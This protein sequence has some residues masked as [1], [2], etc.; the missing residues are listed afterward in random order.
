LILPSQKQD[1]S[2][3]GFSL[4][5]VIIAGGLSAFV[6]GLSAMPI[7]Q[8]KTLEQRVEFQSQLTTAHQ[9]A[10]Q[11]ARN[12]TF[13]KD[14]KRLNIIPGNKSDQ[15]FG[16]RGTGCSAL[17]QKEWLVIDQFAFQSGNYTATSDVSIKVDCSFEKCTQVQVLVSTQSVVSGNNLPIKP[18]KAEFKIPAAALASR[19]E[20]DFSHCTDIATGVTKVITGINYQTLKAECVAAGSNSCAAIAGAGPILTFGPGTDPSDPANCQPP[21]NAKC[22]TGMASI[23]LING[24]TQCAPPP[25]CVDPMSKNCLVTPPVCKP[26]W[27]PSDPNAICLDQV[28]SQSDLNNCGLPAKT[29][30]GINPLVCISNSCTFSGPIKWPDRIKGPCSNSAANLSAGPNSTSTL[31]NDNLG[32]HGNFTATCQDLTPADPAFDWAVAYASSTCVPVQCQSVAANLKW[33]NKLLYDGSADVWACEGTLAPSGTLSHDQAASATNSAPTATSGSVQ[34][35]CV[36]PG[37]LGSPRKADLKVTSIHCVP[38]AAPEKNPLACS[39]TFQET[40]RVSGGCD[41]PAWNN[42]K[43]WL[44]AQLTTMGVANPET[45]YNAEINTAMADWY[46]SN[47]VKIRNTGFGQDSSSY[48]LG[49]T[50]VSF[51]FKWEGA[52]LDPGRAL[53]TLDGSLSGDL[54]GGYCAGPKTR[55]ETPVAGICGSANAAPASVAPMADLCTK[56][57]AS[58]VTGA[59]PFTWTCNGIDGGANV[60]CASMPAVAGDPFNDD[61]PTHLYSPMVSNLGGIAGLDFTRDGKWK[62]IEYQGDGTMRIVSGN[63]FKTAENP[64]DYEIKTS[65]SVQT[66]PKHYNEGHI[67]GCPPGG[68]INLAVGTYGRD[69]EFYGDWQTANEGGAHYG[70]YSLGPPRDTIFTFDVQI[71]KISNPSVTRSFTVKIVISPQF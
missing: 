3:A 43:A 2:Q 23:G 49:G 29:I 1:H 33:S 55:P 39:G 54:N 45:T 17:Q 7:V 19:Q 46:N 62:S 35:T 4:T 57:K 20:I 68:W 64:S 30:K 60:S 56:G 34:L 48:S 51:S 36:D 66:N 70:D 9:V 67:P 18:L 26:N 42:Y 16:G 21:V 6:I 41:V 44:L 5:E 50:I 65:C 58:P 24:Q 28:V 69:Y 27:Q 31:F 59:G 11:K 15:C 40:C 32:Y 47:I 71:R 14:P 13:L 25:D 38:A 22:P 8:M 61:I 53:V 10:L 12:S 52:E 63:I 37:P